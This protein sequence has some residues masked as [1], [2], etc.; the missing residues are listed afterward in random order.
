MATKDSGVP[1]P[2][3]NCKDLRR[4]AAALTH[5]VGNVTFPCKIA[6]AG[7]GSFAASRTPPDESGVSGRVAPIPV[8][9]LDSG[10]RD[11]ANRRT[12]GALAAPPHTCRA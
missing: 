9:A 4:S 12:R 5:P 7:C 3:G 2:P 6:S 1:S 11:A 8:R 10:A